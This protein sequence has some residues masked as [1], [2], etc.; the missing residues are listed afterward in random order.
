M[1]NGDKVIVTIGKKSSEYIV[2]C[3][4]ASGAICLEDAHGR[5]DAFGRVRVALLRADA[6][7]YSFR[8]GNGQMKRLDGNV[9]IVRALR[10]A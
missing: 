3:I 4:L 10:A 7:G 8:T 1:K 2:D 6:D 5:K 9:C